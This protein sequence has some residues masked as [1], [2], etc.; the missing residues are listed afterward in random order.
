MWRTVKITAGM[1]GE[2]EIISTNA[3]DSLIE[4]QLKSNSA[5]MKKGF[6]IE[7]PYGIIEVNGFVANVLGCQDDFDSEDMET[8]I[9]DAEFDY[10]DL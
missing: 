9:I 2:F 8:A 6:V 4:E 10:Y 5:M 1:T 3:P 7:K